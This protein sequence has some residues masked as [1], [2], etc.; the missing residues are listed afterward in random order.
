M[1]HNKVIKECARGKYFDVLVRTF[2]MAAYGTSYFVD[3]NTGVDTQD[4]ESWDTALKTLNVANGKCEDNK[5][6]II[7]F[8]GRITGSLKETAAEIL[9]KKSIHLFGAG[10]LYGKGG[11]C[12]S[13]FLPYP[14]VGAPSNFTIT[15]DI[16]KGG[17][18]VYCGQGFEVAGMKFYGYDVTQLMAHIICGKSDGAPLQGY[19]IHDCDF[20]GDVAGS[21]EQS[22]L[23]LSALE[24][25]YI[26]FNNFY[27][28]EYGI[29]LIAGGA[30]Y[31]TGA[32][33]EENVFRGCKYGIHLQNESCL[34][35][36][37]KNRHLVEGALGRGWAMTQGIL[38]DSGANDNDFED[39]EIYHATKG[40]AITDNG[41]NN[42]FRR[43]YYN[44]TSGA[45]TLYT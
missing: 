4:G 27:Y 36:I 22:G 31:S 45:G 5:Q 30:D 1:G 8:R 28:T 7:F 37:R 13:A 25:P 11:G 24:G 6:N 3:R 26:G 17:L 9:T 32:L 18:E 14:S 16:T 15:G 42:V 35:L 41:S 33:I 34:N 10:Y 12:Y 19:S 2:A 43:C 39:E 23:A 44:V 40:N 38:V 20:Q 21:G 29:T